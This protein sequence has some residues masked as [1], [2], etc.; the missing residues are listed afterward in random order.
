MTED[1]NYTLF[2][3]EFV[4]NRHIQKDN[5]MYRASIRLAV[6]YE[7][8]RE[9]PERE[10]WGGN[11]NNFNPSELKSGW[12]PEIDVIIREL[13]KFQ[14]IKENPFSMEEQLMLAGYKHP[15]ME[16][17]DLYKNGNPECTRVPGVELFTENHRGAKFFTNWLINDD[18]QF[19]LI[20]RTIWH[21]LGFSKPTGVKV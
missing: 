2:D 16:R 21:V 18:M 10:I 19:T 4:S 1:N 15:D 14:H 8:Y 20:R 11:L 17:I 3:I 5:P 6:Y 13:G 12:P 7:A 9:N